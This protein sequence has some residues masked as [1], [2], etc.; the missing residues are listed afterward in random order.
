MILRKPYAFFIKHFK[1]MHII[2]SVLVC[3]SLYNTK[4]LLEFFNE[5]AKTIINVTGQNLY[6]ILI[7]G[8][9]HILPF[10]I[11]IFSI[12]ILVVLAIKKKPNLF[13]IINIFIYIYTFIIIEVSN[14]TL[15]TMSL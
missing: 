8:L 6:E 1:L 9:F 10:L 7:P 12:I 13:Y 11:I 15:H 5:Y 3:Y 14:S 4:E 2:L